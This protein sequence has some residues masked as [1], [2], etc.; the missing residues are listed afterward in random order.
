MA[1]LST[2]TLMC[3]PQGE[4]IDPSATSPIPKIHRLHYHTGHSL[5]DQ[6]Y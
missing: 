1:Y 6:S 4:T 3:S 5:L 2:Y